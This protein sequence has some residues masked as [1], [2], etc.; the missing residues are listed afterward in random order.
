MSYITDG[1]HYTTYMYIQ[2][3]LNIYGEKQAL[4]TPEKVLPFLKNIY[5][6]FF[7]D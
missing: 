5:I 1:K 4:D 2:H 6:K 7:I 3:T